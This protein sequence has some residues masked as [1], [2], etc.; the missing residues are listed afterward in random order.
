VSTASATNDL[1]GAVAASLLRPE[2]RARSRVYR[3]GDALFTRVAAA[4]RV[5]AQGAGE[6]AR[7]V[8]IGELTKRVLAQEGGTG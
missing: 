5:E 6:A 2:G 8:I 4:L 7:A 1:A 3:A